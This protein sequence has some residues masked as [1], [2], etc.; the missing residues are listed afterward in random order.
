[1]VGDMRCNVS[2]FASMITTMKKCGLTALATMIF[3]LSLWSQEVR[4]SEQEAVDE[5]DYV[6]ADIAL[7][8]GD[9]E[10]A[11][12]QY[13]SL[14]EADRS[15]HA[16]CY[17]LARA[18]GASEDLESA[19]KYILKA[20]SLAPANR[21]YRVWHGNMMRDIGRDGAALESYQYLAEKYPEDRYF[22]ENYAFTLLKL[23]EADQAIAVLDAYEARKGVQ[24][25]LTKKKFEIYDARG[26]IS[27]AVQELEKLVKAYPQED[28]LVHNLGAYL[29]K[30]GMDTEAIEVYKRQ[31]KTNPSDSESKMRLAALDGNDTAPSETIDSLLNDGI[32]GLDTK[33]RAMV[34]YIE[35]IALQ[36]SSQSEIST[37]LLRAERLAKTYPTAAKSQ[38]LLGDILFLTGKYQECIDAYQK[39]LQLNSS[40]YAVWNNLMHAQLRSS[41]VSDRLATAESAIDYYPNEVTAYTYYSRALI[42]DKNYDTAVTYLQEAQLVSG[43]NAELLSNVYATRA[44]LHLSRN[45]VAKARAAIDMATGELAIVYDIAGDV[46]LAEGNDKQAL[47]SYKSSYSLLADPTV[48]LKISQLNP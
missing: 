37:A 21:W 16:V 6:T 45:A 36:K 40:N 42:D 4:I 46:S 32:I 17:G 20:I 12:A 22:V 28:R 38:A 30:Q 48:A 24:E 7:L 10:E 15:N 18:Y 13:K 1:M 8:T 31:L 47:A 9:Y 23:G 41:T 33:I 5:K 14:Y 34:P 44:Y 27:K 2:M 43:K 39:T 3:C 25:L 26:D 11:K 35:N 19:E 29:S